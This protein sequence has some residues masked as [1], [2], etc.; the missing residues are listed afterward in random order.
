MWCLEKDFLLSAQHLPGRQNVIVKLES[1]VIR[2]L[3]DW[4]LSP[5]IFQKI[6]V[7]MDPL[8][9]DLLESQIMKH[10]ASNLQLERP[11]CRSNRCIPPGLD[12]SNGLSQPYLDLVGRV[13]AKVKQQEANQI[14]IALI[15]T[16]QPWCSLLL[17]L[18]LQD[19]P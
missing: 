16:S 17:S 11:F 8:E 10:S 19:F 13:L 6:Q 14:L 1:R 12:K 3:S 7:T 15:W 4:M 2:D 5:G 18:L 9:E